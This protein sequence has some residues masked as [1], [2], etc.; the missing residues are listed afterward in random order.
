MDIF[1]LDSIL[2]RTETTRISNPTLMK[3]AS[4]PSSTLEGIL[5]FCGRIGN[6]FSFLIDFDFWEDLAWKVCR[7]QPGPRIDQLQRGSQ[8]SHGPSSQNRHVGCV[9]FGRK[10]SAVAD[11]GELY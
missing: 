1:F 10:G 9:V 5:N 8:P 3:Q 6:F 7:S 2:Q 11:K 4:F